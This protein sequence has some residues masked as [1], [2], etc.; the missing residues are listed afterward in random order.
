MK[1]LILL[2]LV[3]IGISVFS[4]VAGQGAVVYKDWSPSAIRTVTIGANH[5]TIWGKL[6]SPWD[7]EG[8]CYEGTV[9]TGLAVHIAGKRMILD[10][11][12]PNGDEIT[13]LVYTTNG[14]VNFQMAGTPAGGQSI[15]FSGTF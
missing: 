10:C 2:L 13:A 7:S 4:R 3:T 5:L 6:G 8:V 12:T 11:P 9:A 15:K 14:V 1:R